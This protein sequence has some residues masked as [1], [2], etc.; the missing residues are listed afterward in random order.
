MQI[1][2]IWD[3]ELN[4]TFKKRISPVHHLSTNFSKWMTSLKPYTVQYSKSFEPFIVAKKNIVKYDRR[5]YYGWDRTSHTISLVAEDYEFIVLPDVFMVHRP[6]RLYSGI[7][8]YTK[9]N[10][11]CL[12][13][14]QKQFIHELVRKTGK[15]YLLFYFS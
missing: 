11:H 10:M 15:L 6:H 7:K 1:G 5:F 9:K 13:K 2:R 8:S 12:R 3:P 14:L 4:F